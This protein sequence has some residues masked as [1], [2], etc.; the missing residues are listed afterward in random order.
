MP[1]IEDHSYT[2]LCSE[3][4]RILSISIAS[5]KRKVEIIAMKEGK[6]DIAE[7]KSIVQELI[8]KYDLS[9]SNKKKSSAS[10]LDQLLE[11]VSEDDNFMVED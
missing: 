10:Q 11:V 2:K 8:K 6:K 4:A 7:K 1:F 5:A 9:S 3:L